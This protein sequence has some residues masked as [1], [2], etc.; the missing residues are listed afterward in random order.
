MRVLHSKVLPRMIPAMSGDWTLTLVCVGFSVL[1]WQIVDQVASPKTAQKIHRVA[2]TVF[3]WIVGI[4][5]VG[6]LVGLLDLGWQ[7]LTK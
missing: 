2:G 6:G 7:H 4:F 3:W 1:V 5:V